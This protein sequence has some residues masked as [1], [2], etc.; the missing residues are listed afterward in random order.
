MICLLRKSWDKQAMEDVTPKS[1]GALKNDVAPKDEPT[2]DPSHKGALNPNE[3]LDSM[4]ITAHK[5]EEA[6]R[7]DLDS[8]VTA[9]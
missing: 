8:T 1:N 9:P 5:E 6:S 7:E 3:D 4:E 2:E